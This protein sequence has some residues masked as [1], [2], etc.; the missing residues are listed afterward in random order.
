MA[1]VALL[2]AIAMVAVGCGRD[3][4]K[5]EPRPPVPLEV[6]VEINEKSV[7]VSPPAFGAGLVNFTVANTTTE[8]AAFEIDG[9]MKEVSDPIP[10]NGALLFKVTMEPGDYEAGVDDS[11]SIKRQQIK[12]GPER[13]SAQNDLL[14]P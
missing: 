14:L 2:G 5:N 3:D 8:E 4:F 11:L 9:P 13:E 1:V 6:T 7:Q 10:P 12:V